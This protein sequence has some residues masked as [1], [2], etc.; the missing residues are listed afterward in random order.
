MG[1]NCVL[2]FIYI[3]GEIYCE[4]SGKERGKVLL[5]CVDDSESQIIVNINN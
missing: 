4:N 5:R 1:G 3:R 2:L